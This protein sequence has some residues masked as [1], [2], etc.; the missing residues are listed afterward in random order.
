MLQSKISFV[1]DRAGGNLDVYT[2]DLDGSNLYRVTT[3]AED[4]FD[5]SWAGDG[6]R[7]VFDTNRNGHWD[8]YVI[9]VVGTNTVR[10]TVDPS[11]DESPVWR[12]Y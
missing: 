7:L 10:L 5:T 2:V 8:I 3:E 12:P 4:D 6:Q 9:D 11:D 1:S